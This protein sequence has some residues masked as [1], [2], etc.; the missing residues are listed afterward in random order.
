MSY[1]NH[2]GPDDPRAVTAW[3]A[4]AFARA[5]E[6]QAEADRLR[7]IAAELAEPVAS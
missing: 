7:K 1:R 4:L 5:E 2:Y 3:R 6:A